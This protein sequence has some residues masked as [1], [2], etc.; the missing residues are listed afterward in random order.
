MLSLGSGQ[1]HA[2]WREPE[3]QGA[4]QKTAGRSHGWSC[5]REAAGAGREQPAFRAGNQGVAVNCDALCDARSPDR[6][7]LLARAVILV[8]GM[9]ISEAAREAVLTRVVAELTVHQ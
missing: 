3:R 6:I 1:F 9:A 8:A 7:E 2:H 5:R 4:A